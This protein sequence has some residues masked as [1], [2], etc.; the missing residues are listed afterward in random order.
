MTAVFARFDGLAVGFSVLLLGCEVTRT[1]LT[2]R[3][4]HGVMVRLR[5]YLAILAALGAVFSAT[6][7]TPA[8]Q[9]L[10]TSGARRGFGEAGIQFQ[11]LHTQ[12]ELIGKTTVLLAV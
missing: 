4:T 2:W 11:S 8:I 10:Y 1:L 6:R 12:S 9:A 5:R 7:L 3:G